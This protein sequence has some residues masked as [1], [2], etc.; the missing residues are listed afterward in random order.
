MEFDNINYDLTFVHLNDIH[1]RVNGEN[2]G[3]DISKL[4]TF[5]E[6]LRKN[7]N[8][9]QVFLIDSGDTLHGTSFA[10]LSKGKSIIDIFNMLKVDYTT[11]GNHDFNYGYNHLKKL[12]LLQNYKTLALNLIDNDSNTIPFDIIKINGFNI[13]FFGIITPETYYKTSFK[14]IKDLTISSPEKSFAELLKKLKDKNI[15]FYV[16][17]TH[18]GIDT[19]TKDIYRSLNLAEK[20]TEINILFDGHSHTEITEKYIFNNTL[21][22]QSGNYNKKISLVQVKLFDLDRTHRFKYK[23]LDKNYIDSYKS[24]FNIKNKIKL[25]QKSQE[26][27][28]KTIIGKCSVPLIGDRELVRRSETNFTHLITDAILWKTNCDAVLING[29]SIRDSINQGNITIGDIINSLPFGNCIVTKKIKGSNLKIALENGLKSY[30]NSLGAMAQV[31][32][33]EVFFNPN[34][35]PFKKITNIFINKIPLSLDLDYCIAMTDFMSL[36][37]EEYTSLI[38]GDEIEHYSSVED[39]VIEYIKNFDINIETQVTPRL[40]IDDN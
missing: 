21:I 31:S 15:D 5:L 10:N 27:I 25:I 24:N 40:I 3:I 9:G 6:E 19:S 30:P 12:L 1:G 23:L 35:I 34:N 7:K 22:S 36:G 28:T 18:L 2:N 11:L 4:F 16:G 17:I 14:N 26:L 29:G 13:C 39:I 37:G 38:P 32:G 8:N 20:F 33:L